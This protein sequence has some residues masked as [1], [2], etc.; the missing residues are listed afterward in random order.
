M[1]KNHMRITLLRNPKAGNGKHGRKELVNALEKAGH[2]TICRSLKKKGWKAALKKQADVV[3]VAGGDGAM[4]KVA[5]A[6]IGRETPLA[7]L[8]FGTANN[9]AR[10]LGFFASPKEIIAQLKDRK[11]RVFD[12]GVAK[13]P[14]GKRFL[15][16]GAGAG[17]LADYVHTANKET[18]KEK[19]E[20]ERNSRFLFAGSKS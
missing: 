3:V 12:V 10:S 17:L 14:W 18:E 5:S 11:E 15:F 9:L 6:L 2:Q 8:P 20:K 16:E 13:G 4:A 7:I 1:E 19:E